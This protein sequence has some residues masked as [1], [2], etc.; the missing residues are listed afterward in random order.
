MIDAKCTFCGE[1]MQ[2]RLPMY[3]G[4]C[5]CSKCN[6]RDDITYFNHK[7]VTLEEAERLDK[8]EN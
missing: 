7:W 3:A 5:L 4:S 2:V 1:E 6:D 8:L